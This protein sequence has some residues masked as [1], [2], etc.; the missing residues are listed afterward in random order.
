VKELEAAFEELKGKPVAPEKY[1]R[2]QAAKAMAAALSQ[3]APPEKA[4]IDAFDL[5]EPVNV[6]QK[7]KIDEWLENVV[8]SFQCAPTSHHKGFA[9]MVNQKRLS[10]SFDCRS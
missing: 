3:T 10:R 4:E 1:L 8:C 2:S 7:I 5:M 6:L 9:K